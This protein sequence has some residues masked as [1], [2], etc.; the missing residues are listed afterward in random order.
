MTTI[1]VPLKTSQLQF[2]LKTQVMVQEGDI[3]GFQSEN[4]DAVIYEESTSS[5]WRNDILSAK[6]DYWMTSG[7]VVDPQVYQMK[8][9]VVCRIN[10]VYSTNKAT[11]S[12][13]NL[14]FVTGAGV[15]NFTVVTSSASSQTCSVT[16]M[17]D[18]RELLWVY[19]EARVQVISGQGPP[20]LN[21]NTEAGKPY[22]LTVKL[23]QGTEPSVTWYV[24]NG[25]GV[26]TSFV[27]SCPTSVANLTEICQFHSSLLE[28][29][30]SSL[31]HVFPSGSSLTNIVV[32]VTNTI[33]WKALHVS[34][35]AYTAVSEVEFYH[36]KC[37]NRT[38]C[39][40]TVETAKT[41]VFHLHVKSGDM[42]NAVFYEDD[43][44]IS[45]AASDIFELSRMF[46]K[47]ATYI[48]S[49]NVSNPLSWMMASLRV[50]A[51]I[52][53]NFQNLKFNNVFDK[54]PV[55][56]LR[57]ISA[58]VKVTTGAY[59]LITWMFNEDSFQSNDQVIT[60]VLN[61][62]HTYKFSSTG[63]LTITLS[64]S[65]MFGNNLS[66]SFVV[67]VYNSIDVPLNLST[68]S[69]YV[70]TNQDFNLTIFMK[71]DSLSDSV[72]FGMLIYTVDWND[73]SEVA[74][75]RDAEIM[76]ELQYKYKTPGSFTIAVTVQ[77]IYN[78][79]NIQTGTIIITTQDIIFGLN[80]TYDGPKHFSENVTFTA[81]LQTGSDVEYMVNFG[82]NITVSSFQTDP[83]FIYKYF[84][85]DVYWAVV[86]ARNAVSEKTY[87]LTL[88][89]YDENLL[90][91]IG[92]N[93][94][95]CVPVGKQVAIS[96]NVATEA[97]DD[98]FYD[99]TFGNGEMKSGHPMK[100]I[101]TSY[102][103]IGIYTISLTVVKAT[104]KTIKDYH[105]VDIY[106][107]EEIADLSVM[108]QT[109]LAL[110]KA[111]ALVYASF[112]ASVRSGS[113]LTYTWTIN[114]A[115]YIAQDS[116]LNLTVTEAKV[117]NVTVKVENKL[118]SLVQT[119][120]L[121][122]IEVITGLQMQ[123]PACS[124]LYY[125]RTQHN[126]T[127]QAS[128]L[129]GT[130]VNYAWSV[131]N[132][133]VSKTGKSMQ[134][135]FLS[136]GLHL[137]KLVAYNS[138]SN[139]SVAMSII[140]QDEV[141]GVHINTNLSIVGINAKVTFQATFTS[142]TSVDI[143][144]KCDAI[145][146]KGNNSTSLNHA[147][148]SAGYHQCSVV[149]FND[150][151]SMNESIQISVLEYIKDVSI[152]HS[153]EIKPGSAR[154][155]ATVGKIY[156]F[157]PHTNT[158]LLVDFEWEIQDTEISSVLSNASIL[159]YTFKA[160]G[161]Y[162]LTL[163]AKNAISSNNVSITVEAQ[164][165]IS[166]VHITTNKTSPVQ[167]F[168][169]ESVL[170]QVAVGTGSNL[171]Y[172]W[173][174]GGLTQLSQNDSVVVPFHLDGNF[175]V[176]V[177]VMNDIGTVTDKVLV[178]VY[179][180]VSNVT[181]Q[182]KQSLNLPFVTQGTVLYLY[183]QNVFGSALIYTWTI[184]HVP[185]GRQFITDLMS[186]SFNCSLTGMYKVHLMVKNALS[187]EEDQLILMVQ[188][189]VTELR[190]TIQD[191]VI[192]TGSSLILTGDVNLDATDVTFVWKIDEEVKTAAS[193][194]RLFPMVGVFKVYVTAANNVS[195][196]SK[197]KEIRVLDPISNLQIADCQKIRMAQV[198]TLLQAT[199]KTGTNVTYT[200]FLEIN[201][202]NT[203]Y[204]GQ[205]ISI[206]FQ[207]AGF[208]NVVLKADNDINTKTNACQLRLQ[209]PISH[210]NLSVTD[211]RPDYIIQNQNVTFTA[212]GNNL[213]SA[214]FD[215][216][217]V[218]SSSVISKSNKF[219]TS[220][221]TPGN[222]VAAVIISNGV[223]Q[224]EAS[225]EFTVKEFLCPGLP[226]VSRVGAPSRSLLRSQR[227]ELEVAIDARNCTSY[228]AVHKWTV[229][230]VHSECNATVDTR[231]KVRV[232]VVI[233]R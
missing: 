193:F 55:G 103:V 192:A 221:P 14:N 170:F 16:A 90:R 5:E 124:M 87:K 1:R 69:R 80:L 12:P 29:P 128:L 205:N 200:W 132:S 38:A 141:K 137:V 72:S 23:L 139:E 21:I 195:S 159:K 131:N 96:A 153:L 70:P 106:V 85:A 110:K 98:L 217:I 138:V 216:K 135:N 164:Q 93:V 178:S 37:S 17:E 207:T 104:S 8:S 150:V 108:F 118:N 218:N 48:L 66:S 84:T 82:D 203:T 172:L 77:S 143:I 86:T 166:N 158:H 92:I 181:I 209:L 114:N 187:Y 156:T 22:D 56:N 213:F 214:V 119:M 183:C 19:P 91:I 160:N 102:G 136:P 230:K 180:R 220:I 222:Y 26:V 73:G 44:I 185:S 50:N 197:E 101:T 113:N 6:T 51:Q 161:T 45:T 206:N 162:K 225:V 97:P 224:V 54:I 227:L 33:S 109:P 182:V 81:A 199:I 18:V 165:N 49:V 188:G 3:L 11:L 71:S 168:L 24:N 173:S 125:T 107:E 121:T 129:Y 35:I 15:Y 76:Q 177:S 115:R 79:S 95:S 111:G 233:V 42:T 46:N 232:Y 149:I 228:L 120:E 133:T 122:A 41:H 152:N 212:T 61:L 175:T 140:A 176:Q 157:T 68:S 116:T 9:D 231:H 229:V 60:P 123:C 67:E 27:S 117:Y 43:N 36:E 167:I 184:T 39:N 94:K 190:V 64:T 74:T 186:V 130:L 194:I 204:A 52:K 57:N 112:H 63:N 174:S 78:S 25:S 4:K 100:H 144:W 163:T 210:A 171:R 7:D 196:M 151:S 134:Y 198:A 191:S 99:W 208:Y 142:G 10:A 127:L 40:V 211:P 202:Q 53:A 169:G 62:S 189:A 83:V 215:W 58:S 34:I 223:S 154:L 126:T 219:I 146:V 75:W 32:N 13:V 226:Y 47:S 28:S 147:F 2:E 201:E 20:V 65:D 179:V 59:I 31:S 88:Y 30:Y 89:V 155:Y 148:T 145:I 105:K